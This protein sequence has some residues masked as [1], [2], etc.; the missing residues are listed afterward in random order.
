MKFNIG[1]TVYVV[2]C[3]IKEYIGKEAVIVDATP[4]QKLELFKGY[5][6]QFSPNI[7]KLRS[8]GY[9]IIKV[10]GATV[11]YA[12]DWDLETRVDRM[13]RRGFLRPCKLYGAKFQT[14]DRV[15]VCVN[16]PD[17]CGFFATIESSKRINSDSDLWAYK[18]S[19]NINLP[20]WVSNAEYKES[21]LEKM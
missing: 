10:N 14:G 21:M 15:R 2:S 5:I 11:G 1:D 6:G 18:I 13:V 3:P 19:P 4:V 16:F 9:Y 17:S 20:E 8:T 12:E 7:E